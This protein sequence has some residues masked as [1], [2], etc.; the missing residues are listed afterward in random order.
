[1]TR[2]AVKLEASDDQMKLIEIFTGLGM[3]PTILHESMLTNKWIDIG[4]QGEDPTTDFR[5]T[6]TL[7]L[8]NLHN[9]VSK[10]Q[11]QA[12]ACLAHA[13]D[14]K[15]EYF[16]ACSGINVTHKMINSFTEPEICTHFAGAVSEDEVL[17]IFNGLYAEFIVKLDQYWVASPQSS[18][19]MNFN[20]VMVG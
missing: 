6:G 3:D 11:K 16:L 13:R 19:F 15:S 8:L 7:G 5:G 1:M 20:T 9:F 10:R 4:F 2:R 18:N 12:L 17:N 14:K